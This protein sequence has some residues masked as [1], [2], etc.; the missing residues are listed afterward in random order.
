MPITLIIPDVIGDPLDIIASGP[1]I[2]TI[3]TA[4]KLCKFGEVDPRRK[5]SGRIYEVLQKKL[6]E[7]ARQRGLELPIALLCDQSH[8]GETTRFASTQLV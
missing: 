8:F 7:N 5:L 1:T 4:K 2:A 3:G 6:G